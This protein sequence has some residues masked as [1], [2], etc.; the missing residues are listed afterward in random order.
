MYTLHAVLRRILDSCKPGYTTR[1]THSLTILIY[2][3]TAAIFPARMS[4]KRCIEISRPN[5]AIPG[6]AADGRRGFDID[7]LQPF[8][9]AM[10]ETVEV[11]SELPFRWLPGFLLSLPLG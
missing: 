5:R 9:L 4:V 3:R 6:C 8:P 11:E 10:D 1:I 7:S 2:S